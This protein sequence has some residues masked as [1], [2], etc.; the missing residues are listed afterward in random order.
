[1]QILYQTSDKN[2]FGFSNGKLMTFDASLQFITDRTQQDVAYVQ[3]L[4]SKLIAG[5]ATDFEKAEWNSTLLKGAYNYTDLNRVTAAMEYLKLRLE[6]YGYTVPGYQ[7][8]KIPHAVT[9]GGS[10]LPDGYTE[11]AYIESNGRQHI[12]TG[13]T[14]TAATRVICDFQLTTIPTDASILFR[15]SSYGFGYSSTGA[16]RSWGGA[17]ATFASSIS[18]TDRH[19]LDKQPTVCILDDTELP[20]TA[21]VDQTTELPLFGYSTNGSSVSNQ[22]S[23]KLYYFQIYDADVLVRDFVPCKNSNGVVG[24]Y[25]LVSNA[26]YQNAGSGVFT[27]GEETAPPDGVPSV[28][29][30]DPYTWYEYDW[31]TPEAMTLY[32]LNVSAI[33]SVLTVMESTPNVPDYTVGFMVKEVNDIEVILM[34]VYRQINIMATTFISCGEAL[35]GGDNL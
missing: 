22:I 35:S 9:G 19:Y 32:L 29:E 27:A 4:A 33:R 7:K 31:P 17:T 10:R 11:V 14:V 2:T 30:H 6:Q 1:M 20:L 15:T 23:A 25:D 13:W 24:L 5:T 21:H 28:D 3:Q 12:W 8:I 16:F 18:V 34:D 26:F